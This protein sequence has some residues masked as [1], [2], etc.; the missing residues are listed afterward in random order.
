MANRSLI[1]IE[2]QIK[3]LEAEA[4]ELGL[5]EGAEQFWPNNMNS[6]WVPPAAPGAASWL[7]TWKSWS[8]RLYGSRGT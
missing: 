2:R 7:T 4:E 3:A 1:E 5:A 8:T 6:P